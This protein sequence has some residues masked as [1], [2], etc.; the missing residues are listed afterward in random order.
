MTRPNSL[1]VA[2]L[3]AT[4][5]TTGA[6][7][8]DIQP[9]ISLEGS[10]V[11]GSSSFGDTSGGGI[12]VF[13]PFVNTEDAYFI[14]LS[15]RL[16][17]GDAEQIS[18]G[19][20]YR[21]AVGDWVLGINGYF[22]Y[23]NS[24]YDNDFTQLSVGV[25][26]LGARQEFRANAYFPLNDE[27][28]VEDFNRAYVANRSLVFR[29]GI[30][31][32]E[33]GADIEAG[34]HLPVFD[35]TSPNQLRAFGG[36]YWYDGR[37]EDDTYGIRGRAELVL[38]D[39]DLGGNDA[40]ITFGGT[41]SSDTTDDFL[42]GV[43]ARLRVQLGNGPLG[44]TGVPN[45]FVR[46][47]YRAD[48][49]RTRAGAFGDV[50]AALY[51][52]GR[53]VGEV[54]RVWDDIGGATE[55][56][57]R[58]GEAGD[59]A[60]VLA[61][62]DI[63]VSQTIVLEDGQYLLGGGG[64]LRVTGARSGGEANFYNRGAAATFTGTD[65]SQ[66]IIAMATGS[67]ISHASFQGGRSAIVAN[68]VSDLAIRNVTILGSTLNG[69]DLRNV[70]NVDIAHAR[71]G[72][73]VPCDDATSCR[74][75]FRSPNDAPGAGISLIGAQD[76]SIADSIVAD[77]NFGIFAASEI[78]PSTGQITP[79]GETSNIR[80]DNVAVRDVANEGFLFV[81]ANDIEANRITIENAT[82]D[83]IVL[84]NTGDV[85]IRDLATSGGVNGI[86]MNTVPFGFLPGETTN[87]EIDGA[88]ISG[89]SRAGL[90]LN[91]ISGVTL[92]NVEIL[93]AGTVGIALFGSDFL[94][95]V[96]NVTFDNVSITR[97]AE[98]ALGF[99]GPA[100]NLAG[101]VTLTEVAQD[102]TVQTFVPPTESLLTQ[103]PGFELVLGGTPLDQNN[104]FERCE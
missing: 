32:A 28:V 56:N 79:D 80:F 47:V 13:I 102:C 76:V 12:G 18:A 31:Q 78:D 52:D 19:V 40:S 36:G 27:R 10:Y 81:S 94:G 22:D 85:T 95:P 100:R 103:D 4:S 45:R 65:T 44:Q 72:D 3:A 91:P 5:L 53:T 6:F 71:I 86:L 82:L 97:P 1:I 70:E 49:I 83:S 51:E 87:I 92:R 77:T 46:E 43:S 89:T 33:T 34:F 15:G 29:Q 93:D 96:E 55:I 30:E 84:L 75:G 104:F 20:G 14:D 24:E 64:G 26:A 25:E 98:G 60:L 57:D 39:F 11:G 90:F 41:V 48:R 73:F 69:I 62:G 21:Q 61:N 17:D 101:E 74:F 63:S 67:T 37:N 38:A 35:S 23:L 58:L 66:D 16:F 50:E 8:Q 42:A 99:R 59:D 68:D 2:M 7:A 54:V 88:T 9:I